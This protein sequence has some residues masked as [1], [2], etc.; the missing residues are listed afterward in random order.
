M[1]SA[2]CMQHGRVYTSHRA[3]RQNSRALGH[4]AGKDRTHGTPKEPG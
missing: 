2:R 4:P 1:L 3:R